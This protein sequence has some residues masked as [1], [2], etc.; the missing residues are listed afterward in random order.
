MSKSL[1]KQ[2]GVR[3]LAKLANVSVGTVDRALNGR[4]EVN[5]ETRRRILRIAAEYGYTPNPAAR[6]L[7]VG[8]PNIKI[9]VCIPSEIHYFYDQLRDGIFAETEH[10]THLGIEVLYRPVKTLTSSASGVVSDLLDSGVQTLVVTPGNPSEMQPLIDEAERRRNVRVVCVVTDVSRSCRSASVSVN[11]LVSGMMAAD[12]MSQFVPVSS[13]VAAVTGMISI[14]EHGAKMEGFRRVF[15][16]ECSA[17]RV[18][19]VIEGHEDE[20]ETFEKCRRLLKTRPALRGIYVSTVNCIPVCQAIEQAGAS[21]TVKVIATDLFA[22]AVAYFENRTISASIYQNPF[23]Q[24][25][26]AV[27]LI[28]DHFAH[29]RPLPSVRYLNPTIVLRSNLGLFRE[30]RGSAGLIEQAAEVV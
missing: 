8:R 17:G 3:E 15:E 25:Q 29:S 7:S 14:E 23:R 22:E 24:G 10:F 2:I 12:L 19:D 5:E 30:T 1:M 13:E 6:A 16:R 20:S 9:G 11:P 26:T 28:V 21:G 27:R 18:I 4:K